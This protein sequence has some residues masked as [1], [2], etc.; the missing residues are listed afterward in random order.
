M[1]PQL[2]KIFGIPRN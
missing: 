2:E 1:T